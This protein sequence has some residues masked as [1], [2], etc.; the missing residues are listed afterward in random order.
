MEMASEFP[1]AQF[2]GIDIYTMYPSDIKPPNV[3]FIQGNVL[4]GL[5][6]DDATF[7]F[8]H[9]SYVSTCFSQSDRRVVT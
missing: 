8:V 3:H 5:P 2:Y 6:Y 4:E 9:M 7:D 1:N